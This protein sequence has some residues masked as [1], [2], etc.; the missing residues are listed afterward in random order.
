MEDRAGGDR[1]LTA[2]GGAFIGKRLGIE[3]PGFGAMAFRTDE[4]VRPSFFK[5]MASA[6][7]VVGKPRGEGGSRHGAVVFPTAR[8][9]N[10]L[11]TSRRVVKA[12]DR[13]L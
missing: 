12:R 2:A 4:A 8:H 5:E 9:E 10:K 11:G 13:H 3:R 1:C 7:R 6:G